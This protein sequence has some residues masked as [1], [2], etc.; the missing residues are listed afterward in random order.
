[1][2][3][4]WVWVL[5]SDPESGEAD[6]YRYH[7]HHRRGRKEAHGQV[8][9]QL[10]Q[11]VPV[12]Q[13]EEA[14]RRVE[15]AVPGQNQ[16]GPNSLLMIVEDVKGSSS[17]HQPDE[18]A[19]AGSRRVQVPQVQPADTAGLRTGPEPGRNRPYQGVYEAAM[20]K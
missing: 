4:F 11:L 6:G 1:M 8:E 9:D 20:K 14:Q 19:H 5:G 15:A 7:E 16:P 3:W 18:P 2:R 12:A 13:E 10:H 17:S